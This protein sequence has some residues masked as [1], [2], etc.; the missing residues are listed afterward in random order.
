MPLLAKPRN[1]KG[2]EVLTQTLESGPPKT[3]PPSSL[4]ER[5]LF[6]EASTHATPTHTDYFSAR[7]ADDCAARG[8]SRAAGRGRTLRHAASHA[9]ARRDYRYARTESVF[10]RAIS[11]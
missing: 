7:M 1:Y 11:G 3:L 9:Q 10:V 5:V 6:F 2:S 4:R 8:A